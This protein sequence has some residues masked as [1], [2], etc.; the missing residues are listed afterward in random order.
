MSDFDKAQ[1]ENVA[2]K[3]LVKLQEEEIAAL[4]REIDS[5]KAPPPADVEP[6]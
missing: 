1:L 2:L 3:R 6:A 5:L 4:K